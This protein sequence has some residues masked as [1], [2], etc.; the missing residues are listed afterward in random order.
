MGVEVPLHLFRFGILELVEPLEARAI[1]HLV[2]SL[3]EAAELAVE[4]LDLS[5]WVPSRGD[6]E[7]EAERLKLGDARGECQSERG[8]SRADVDPEQ[9]KDPL[10]QRPLGFVE[11]RDR[12]RHAA[13]LPE[14]HH[15]GT[16]LGA[17]T[18]RHSDGRA[19]EALPKDHRRVARFSACHALMHP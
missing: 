19:L 1:A 9:I 14:E 18:A 3:G 13:N 2:V 17:T 12:D 4:R 6:L 11:L 10:V 7:L 8:T 15:A 5:L 16:P